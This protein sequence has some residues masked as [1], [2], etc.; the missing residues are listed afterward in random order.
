LPVI[1][2]LAISGLPAS[3]LEVE[4]TESVFLQAEKSTVDALHELRSFGVRVAMD[5]FGTGYSALSYLR[6]FPFDKIKIDRSFI[7]GLGQPDSEAIVELIANLGA[8]LNMTTVAEGVETAEQLSRLRE[9]GCS[10]AQGYLFSRPVPGAEVPGLLAANG[11]REQ[12]A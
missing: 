11:L 5:D 8:R 7:T 1:N 9:L 10:A 4:L 2:A 6:T 12:A 3:R